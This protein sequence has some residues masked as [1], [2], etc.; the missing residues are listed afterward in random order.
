MRTS[1]GFRV[2]V[3]NIG[4]AAQMLDSSSQALFN[5]KGQKFAPCSAIMS[6]KDA[7]KIFLTNIN[8]GNSITGAPLLFD[9]AT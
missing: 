2:N 9:V 1:V 3:T 8:P 6:L 5:N 4:D 7:D